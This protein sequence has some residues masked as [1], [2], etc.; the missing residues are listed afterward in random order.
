MNFF[1][2]DPILNIS[3]DKARK[4]FHVFESAEEGTVALTL[5]G[6]MYRISNA[7]AVLIAAAIMNAALH[8]TNT[9]GDAE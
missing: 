3:T 5:G 9:V 1:L 4:W 2:T 6:D 7:D 8:G